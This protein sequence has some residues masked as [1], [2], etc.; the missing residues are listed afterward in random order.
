MSSP[1]RLCID[2]T[3]EA[4]PIPLSPSTHTLNPTITRTSFGAVVS[5]ISQLGTVAMVG[6]IGIA[7]VRA[8]RTKSA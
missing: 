5:S 6:L 3:I 8:T 4:V 7:A 2:G 1:I